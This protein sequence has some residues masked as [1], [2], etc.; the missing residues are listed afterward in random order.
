LHKTE[1]NEGANTSEHR[2]GDRQNILVLFTALMISMVLGFFM[3]KEAEQG[4]V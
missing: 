4:S 3:Q 2:P 1:Y